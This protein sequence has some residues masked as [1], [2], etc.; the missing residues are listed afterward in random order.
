MAALG[1]TLLPCLALG[2]CGD[3]LQLFQPYPAQSH[4]RSIPAE[5]SNEKNSPHPEEIVV[6][7]ERRGEAKVAADTEFNEDEIA[8][9]G[10]DSIKELIDRLAP[11]IGDKAEDFIFL[12]NGKPTGLDKSVLSYPTEAL[13]RLA[14]LKSEAAGIY[15]EAAGKPVINLV[16]KRHFTMWNADASGQFPSAGGQLDTNLSGNRTAINGDLRMHV[17]GLIG[18]DTGLKMSE[19]DLPRLAG[20]FEPF[21]LISAVD[22]LELDPSLSNHL[23]EVITSIT[24]PN[25]D[26]P[27]SPTILDFVGRGYSASPLNPNACKTLLPSR[28]YSNFSIGA[29][30]PIGDF[31]ASINLNLAHMKS[32]SLN[33]IPE[34]SLLVPL[35]NSFSP[36]EKDIM[37]TRPFAGSRALLSLNETNLANASL[38]L[39]GNVDQ[40]QTNLALNISQNWASHFIETQIDYQRAQQLIYDDNGG[41]NPY[42]LWSDDFLIANSNKT[43]TTSF[44]LLAK[45]G[46]PLF[47]LPAGP[48]NWSFNVNFIQ[49]RSEIQQG[50]RFDKNLIESE[51]RR[52]HTILLTS[53]SLP[54]SDAQGEGLSFIG[55]LNL[56]F[57]A[58]KQIVTGS[59][60]QSGYSIN[61]RWGPS[62]SIQFISSYDYTDAAPAIALLDA[63]NISSPTR[64]YD[65]IIGGISEPIVLTGGNPQLRSGHR[66]N[67]S[68]SAILRPLGNEKVTLNV[69]Y[70]HSISKNGV[71]QFPELT[72]AIEAAF[73]DRIE[74]D[75]QGNLLFI[76][77]RPIN[78]AYAQDTDLVTTLAYRKGA[79]SQ[80]KNRSSVDTQSRRSNPLQF[81]FSVTHR[82]RLRSDLTI[83]PGV[84]AINQLELNGQSKHAASFQANM[85]QKGYGVT[86]NGNWSSKASIPADSSFKGAIIKPPF[87]LD[88]SL[89][90][91][92]ANLGLSKKGPSWLKGL[93]ISF[94]VHNLTNSYR[95]VLALDGTLMPSTS[96][97]EIDPIGRTIKL[98]LRK[99]F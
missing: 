14:V 5:H 67:F 65:H 93:K 36:F 48:L 2:L 42:G 34:I 69:R 64:I 80:H 1:T 51:F 32:E 8:S 77:A 75:N 63:P 38:S 71:A 96:R 94:D 78:L 97:S 46:R 79:R 60:S 53:L 81:S 10:S 52:R 20:S 11:L 58:T 90:A 62:S 28:R 95:K 16:L 83:H 31:T 7:A 22:G 17:Q 18:L 26:L 55:D 4:S 33:G 25:F 74:R 66:K 92:P 70:N 89:F 44:G 6:T 39:T 40:W 50:D 59:S 56:D 98:S 72:P 85:S 73:A 76:D 91:E 86:L 49:N 27:F 47:S 19:R 37:I 88:L 12:V 57:S 43:K 84:P 61:G 3:G 35:E 9:Q 82:W 68:F 24:L 15:G 21:G 99:K 41:F 54:I 30:R 23:G 45:I 13:D 87:K 29:T